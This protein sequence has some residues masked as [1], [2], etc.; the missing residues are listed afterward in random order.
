M[1]T[2]SLS[3]IW[4]HMVFATKKRRRT[5]AASH[6]RDS[7]HRYL[8]G[9]CSSQGCM[10]VYVGGATDHVHIL[11]L[12]PKGVTVIELARKV[13][14][15]SSKW[16]RRHDAG[17]LGIEDFRWQTG[18]SVFSVSESAVEVVKQYIFNQMQHHA[19]YSF[20]FEYLRMLEKSNVDYD[21]DHIF[22]DE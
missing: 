21:K 17:G 13:K 11:T 4:V 15:S 22:D 14:A 9:V 16:I 5:M 18:Y 3:K 8:K 10:E 1:M 6:H 2:Q 12:L 20:E 19:R 7:I